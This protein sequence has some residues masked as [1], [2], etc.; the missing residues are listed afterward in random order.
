MPDDSK[1]GVPAALRSVARGAG[2]QVLS[3][4]IVRVLGFVTTFLLTQSLGPTL[5]GIYS[6]GKTLSSI[7]AT[8]TNLGTDQSIV[9]FVPHYGGDQTAQN[10]VFGLAT[11]TSFVGSLVVGAILFVAA[12]LINEYTLQQSLLVPVLRL[13]AFTLAFNTLIGCISNVFRALELPGYQVVSGN[14]ARQTFR[15]FTV[16]VVVAIGATLVGILVAAIVAWLLAFLFAV[17]L[18]FTR[19]DF[20][21]SL[22]G[23]RPSLSRFYNYS[24]PLT[25][26][27]VGSLL[28]NQIDIL[29]VG[30]FLAGRAVGIYNLSTVLSQVLQIPATG[31]NT[32][33]PSIASRMY[34]NGEL[35]DLRML[36]KQVTRWSFTMVALPAVGLFLFS[37]EV[38]AIFGEGFSGGS[39]VL[40]LF[41]IAQV[42]GSLSGPAGYTLI[43][44]D[45]QYLVMIDRWSAGIANVVLNYIFI[46]RY[47]LIGA[48]FA[49]VIVMSA[50][51]IVRIIELWYTE[52]LFPLSLRYLKP[53]AAGVACGLALLL[54]KTISPFT[55]VGLII[56][57]AIIG[58][59]VF[60]SV[61][62][63]LGIEP[64]D[65]E[66]FS[67]ITSRIR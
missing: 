41:I 11:L 7:A 59:V 34:S 13:F 14:I 61:L 52:G 47:G 18:F 51:S 20:R 56:V 48:A 16:G 55:G 1:T 26:S 8:I 44:T 45:H 58:T 50:V 9:R 17:W 15:L 39:G 5:Y 23:S 28:L 22:S 29:M 12:P 60:V 67:D 43:M 53:T 62:L 19:T 57:G 2:A 24:I 25:V 30:T 38:L 63:V 37:S 54:W 10:R 36:Y 65:R 49:T 6:F 31:L 46:T 27:D 21:P 4:G 3:L 64:D 40:S 35:E 33:Y 66:F 42:A 32:I